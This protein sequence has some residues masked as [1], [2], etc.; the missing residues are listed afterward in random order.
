M[1]Q[2]PR[3]HNPVHDDEALLCHF[4]GDSLRRSDTGVMSRLKYSRL[5][6]GLVLFLL[7]CAFL[8]YLIF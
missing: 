7:I 8:L 2:C 4:C 5:L 1:Q 3:C 6:P